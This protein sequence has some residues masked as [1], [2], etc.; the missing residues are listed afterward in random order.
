M[1]PS[2]W[3]DLTLRRQLDH[4][5][6]RL[7]ASRSARSTSERSFKFPDR[8]IAQAPDGIEG[9]AGAGLTALALDLHP[10][11]AAVKTL[12]DCRRGLRRGAVG[13]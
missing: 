1:H 8:R 13:D 10:T 7:V 9:D 12:P 11:V 2:V 4:V 6:W 3:R 5:H